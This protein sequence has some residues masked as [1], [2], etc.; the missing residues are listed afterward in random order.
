[1]IDDQTAEAAPPN[2]LP[3]YN[4]RDAH[5]ADPPPPPC[6]HWVALYLT[7]LGWGARGLRWPQDFGSPADGVDGLQRH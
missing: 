5:L 2:D 3:A 7:K 1:M 4:G 6:L